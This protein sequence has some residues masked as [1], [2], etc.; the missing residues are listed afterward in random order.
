MYF[1]TIAW[2]GSL[3]YRDSE[4]ASPLSFIVRASLRIGGHYSL[5]IRDFG[6]LKLILMVGPGGL[7]PPTNGSLSLQ[8]IVIPLWSADPFFMDFWSP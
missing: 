5:K 8:K 1:I 2:G 3:L 7:E 6:L 4:I